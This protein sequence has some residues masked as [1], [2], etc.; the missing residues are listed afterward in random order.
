MEHGLCWISFV[1][2]TFTVVC[3]QD[4]PLLSNF[5]AEAEVATLVILPYNVCCN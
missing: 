5:H 1:L 4:F 2:L 3:M